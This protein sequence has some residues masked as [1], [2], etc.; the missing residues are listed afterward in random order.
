MEI[1]RLLVQDGSW[2]AFEEDWSNQCTNTPDE[3]DN[4]CPASINMIR[5]CAEEKSTAN[6]A[7]GLTDGKK[8]MA[9]AIAI[10]ANQKPHIGHVLRIREVTVC[11]ELDY[12]VLPE[13]LY[14]DTLIS[15]LNGAV[16]LSESGLRAKHIK[17][18]LRSPSDSVFFKAVGSALD[19]SGVFAEVEAHGAWLTISKASGS[20]KAIK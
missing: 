10:R 5:A 17:M 7:I 18:H 13:S 1:V 2:K 11:P 15:L 16:K 9:A 20:L 8:I 6:W 3:F 19:K 12:G 4:F 14:G